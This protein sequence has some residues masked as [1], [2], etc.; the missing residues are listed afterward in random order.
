MD[1]IKQQPGVFRFSAVH[2]VDNPAS[3]RVMEKAGMAFEGIMRRAA[4]HPNISDEPRDV[5]LYAW[6]R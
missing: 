2:D 4:I 5:A 3:G 1:W 6:V